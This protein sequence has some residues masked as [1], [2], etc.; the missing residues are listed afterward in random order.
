MATTA[1]IPTDNPYSVLA[2]MQDLNT[3]TDD[4][5]RVRY[6]QYKCNYRHCK[7]PNYT[8]GEIIRDDYD[9]F[10]DLMSHH[11]PAESKTF[12]VLKELLTKTDRENAK[13]TD[14]IK[15]IESPLERRERYLNMTCSHNG[16]MKGKTWRYILER[17][18]NYFMWAV[19]NTMGRD[20]LTFATFVE[21]LNEVDKRLIMCTP[22]GK[23]K[24]IGKKFA[25]G[26][27]P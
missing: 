24:Q 4:Q 21:C 23:M 2:T 16:R 17:D 15:L 9:H 13:T 26:S 3:E 8:W 5:K 12:D 19:G 18:Y 10:V 22:K 1:T 6:L 11:V 25:F 27:K 7:Y 14:R 20:T